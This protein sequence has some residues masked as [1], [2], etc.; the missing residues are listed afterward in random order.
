M[1]YQLTEALPWWFNRWV[2]RKKGAVLRPLYQ[3]DTSTDQDRIEQLYAADKARADKKA[4]G[5]NDIQMENAHSS[6]DEITHE[7]PL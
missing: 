1:R 3:F 4:Q 5:G 6:S 7:K 2:L